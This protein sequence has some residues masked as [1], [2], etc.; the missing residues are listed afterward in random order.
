M[1]DLALTK[2]GEIRMQQRGMKKVDIDLVLACGTQV[3]EETWLLR[4]Q[5]VERGI[6]SRKKEIQ[7]LERLRNQKVVVYG[8][9]LGTTYPSRRRDQKRSLMRAREQGLMK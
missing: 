4:Q 8:D 1:S 5:D 6:R 3:D 9:R 7:A 2:H